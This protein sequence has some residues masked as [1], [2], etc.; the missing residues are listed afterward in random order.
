[1]P[2]SNHGGPLFPIR[3]ASSVFLSC[4]LS[5]AAQQST[6]SQQGPLLLQ[7]SLAA[8]TGG[9]ALRDVVITGNARRIAGSDD[10]TG[11]ATLKALPT[12]E[13]R[14]D[15]SFP[16]GGR[17][18]VRANS[19]AGPVG[20]W[21]G[22]DGASHA[23]SQHNLFVGSSWFFSPFTLAGIISAQD[24]VVSHVGHED[25]D[26]SPVECI[27]VSRKVTDL[28]SDAAAALQHLSQMEIYLDSKTLL[29][30]ALSFNSHPDNNALLD[31]PVIIRYSDYRLV[32][33][34]RIAFHVQK[35][36]NNTLTLDLQFESAN[37]NTGLTPSTFDLQ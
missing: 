20:K 13:S 12:G 9:G 25:F 35:F 22:P 18:E 27:S 8:M 28:P 10:E 6:V 34:A 30:T 15:L 19:D 4:L 11:T 21:S 23:Q 17:A 24:L 7:K 32:N 33:G 16:S 3:A 31:I 5:L 37:L 14:V 2:L 26:D 29:P 1:M 36:L